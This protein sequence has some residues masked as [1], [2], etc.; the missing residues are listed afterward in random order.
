MARQ[1][2]AVSSRLGHGLIDDQTRAGYDRG[3]VVL[4]AMSACLTVLLDGAAVAGLP[5]HG[6]AT[7]EIMVFVCPAG[8]VLPRG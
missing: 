2:R 6:A 5:R 4:G 8:Q 7:A 1:G 3:S